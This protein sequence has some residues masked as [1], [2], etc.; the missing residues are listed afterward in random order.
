MSYD[1]ERADAFYDEDCEQ[2]WARLAQLRIGPANFH[3]HAPYLRRF[4]QP[5]DLVLDAGAGPGRFT[6]GRT[7]SMCS[8]PSIA[9]GSAPRSSSIRKL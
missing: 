6:I 3:V 8:P 4:A 9:A 1:P 5:G 2:E 7:D